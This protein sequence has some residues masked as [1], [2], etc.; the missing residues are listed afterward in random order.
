MSLATLIL[1]DV[2]VVLLAL[3]LALAIYRV[4]DRETDA[5]TCALEPTDASP[6]IP[7]GW[8]A[9]FGQPDRDL[10]EAQALRGLRQK[11]L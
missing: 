8:E 2:V 10:F 7:P 1:L 9:R 4:V 3:A 11:Q 5:A 6:D